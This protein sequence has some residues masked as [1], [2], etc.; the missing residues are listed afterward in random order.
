MKVYLFG[1]IT[2]LLF[3]CNVQDNEKAIY[4]IHLENLL[5]ESCFG[6]EEKLSTPFIL[7][8]EFHAVVGVGEMIEFHAEDLNDTVYGGCFKRL[9]L[10]FHL[11][12][13]V[14]QYEFEN[15]NISGVVDTLGNEVGNYLYLSPISFSEDMTKAVGFHEISSKMNADNTIDFLRGFFTFYERINEKWE[16]YEVLF[17][18]SKNEGAIC[19]PYISGPCG[20]RKWVDR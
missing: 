10:D 12:E 16:I 19:F 5:R 17:F 11:N 2:I 7:V 20:N 1:L 14:D 9:E 4:D 6:V 13:K 8:K 3:G 18:E 15:I